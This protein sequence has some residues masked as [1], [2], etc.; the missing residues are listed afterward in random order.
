M[1]NFFVKASVEGYQTALG[2]G[3]RRK[4]GGMDVTIFQQN[5][6]NI[7]TAVRILSRANGNK[8]ITT[9]YVN[10]EEVARHETVR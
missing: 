7:E 4:D 5:D 2:G 8:L 1:R 6:G 9:V 3:P 10:D